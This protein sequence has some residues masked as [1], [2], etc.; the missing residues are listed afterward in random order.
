MKLRIALIVVLL[1]AAFAAL[2]GRASAQSAAGGKL[3][4][5]HALPEGPAV[6][7]FIDNTLSARN[8]A[9][10]RAT[11]Y[12]N[13]TGGAHT[14]IVAATGTGANPTGAP[15]LTAQVTITP[16]KA[17]QL[18]VVAG[19]VAAPEAIVYPQELGPA[20]FGTARIT[21]VH[22]IKDAP[23]VDVLRADGSPLLNGLK[24][25]E[26]FGE[27]DIPAAA[28]SLAVVP[29]GGEIAG[30]VIK[31]TT[32]SLDAGTHT[33]VV[34]VG[35]LEGKVPPTYVVLTTPLAP[36]ANSDSLVRFANVLPGDK[37]V[38]IYANGTLIAAHLAFKD[39]TEHIAIPAAD[40]T[41]E[42][43]NAGDAPTVAPIATLQLK[44]TAGQDQAIT[45]VLMAG[46]DKAPAVV[47]SADNVSALDPAKAR[48]NVIN[49]LNAPA[50]FSVADKPLVS[51]ATAGKITPN[52]ELDRGVY[53]FEL[54]I[55]TNPSPV[56]GT[57]T[58]NGGTLSDLIIGGSSDAPDLILAT[59]GLSEAPGSVPVNISPDA[60]A[61]AAAPT[62]APPPSAP[63]ATAVPAAVAQAPTATLV[64]NT[65]RPTAVVGITGTVITNDG[66]NLKI[67]EYP[68]TDAKTLGLI[69]SGATVTVLGVK[70]PNARTATPAA[71]GTKGVPTPT[72]AATSRAD[73]WLFIEYKTGSGQITGWTLAQH[74]DL[75]FNGKPIRRDNVVDVLTFPQIP[76]DRFGQVEADATLVPPD[77]KRTIGTVTTVPGTNAQ[78]RRTPSVKGESLALVPSGGF[79]YILGKTDVPVT[80]EIGQPKSPIWFNVQFDTEGS[81]VIGWMSADFLKLSIKYNGKPVDVADVP[82]VTEITPGSIQGNA[83]QVLLPTTPGITAQVVL[84]EASANLQLRRE[85]NQNAE[86]LGL[87][88][89]NSVV[90]V[91]G[92]NGAGSWIEISFE[93][94][95][96]WANATFLKVSRNGRPYAVKDLKI[97]NGEPDTF[98]TTTPT[99]TPVG[100]G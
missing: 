35:E 50:N 48:I 53:R 84:L 42:L 69:P 60:P 44:L 98:G 55:G 7:I 68:R 62:V 1:V 24:Y 28:P 64:V 10:G 93:G 80:G 6:D 81:S 43:R 25:G 49:L 9:F 38:D 11:R 79:V 17:A 40:T 74:L 46:A 3:R 73:I 16:D 87:I 54:A 100:A 77:D 19:N 29:A 56:K 89:G 86:S 39:T 27:V 72:L 59:T 65:P 31:P 91:L 51:G 26:V 34:A 2:S 20:K 45:A 88:P 47:T 30:A 70:G 57:L 14:V 71:F 21:A 5:L 36:N 32:V 63:T 75:T 61:V 82:T 96:G 76:D 12:L 97:T 94:K 83:T 37:P 90:N 78:L 67:R 92:R 8:V 13:V 33:T 66:V 52:A 41:V 95:T 58:V 18:I 99:P 4:F 15:L 22:A 85:P 23:P